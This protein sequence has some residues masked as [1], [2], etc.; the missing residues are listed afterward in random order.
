MWLSGI[1]GLHTCRPN[2][3]L[4]VIEVFFGGLLLSQ[5]VGAA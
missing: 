4:G 2:A 3:E 5:G 1:V